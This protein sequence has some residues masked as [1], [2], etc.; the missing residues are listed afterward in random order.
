MNKA[1]SPEARD[2][3]DEIDHIPFDVESLTLIRP[4]GSYI[5]ACEKSGT[6]HLQRVKDEDDGIIRFNYNHNHFTPHSKEDLAKVTDSAENQSSVVTMPH[7]DQLK[8][9]GDPI[10]L[11][12]GLCMEVSWYGDGSL[13]FHFHRPKPLP[14]DRTGCCNETQ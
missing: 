14:V 3:M 7:P 5:F 6:A 2:P 1:I 9:S 11:P 8:F 10:D 4:V 12:Q 13:R